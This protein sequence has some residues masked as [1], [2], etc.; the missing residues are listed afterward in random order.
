MKIAE[1]ISEG[2]RLLDLARIADT[3][4]AAG[5]LLGHLL[6]VDRTYLLTRSNEPVD[7][8]VY[9]NYLGLIR[10]RAGGEPLQ[11]ITGRQEF[12]GLDFT[13]TPDVLIPRPETEFLVE[14]AIELAGDRALTI[15]DVG[16]GSGC[17]AVALA[18]Y[19]PAA[20]VIATEIS[21]PALRVARSNAERHNVAERI[22]FLE[23]DLLEPLA[24]LELESAV[25]LLVSNPPYVPE[26]DRAG[27]QTEVR[28][29][30]PEGALFGGDEGLDFYRRLLAEGGRVVKPC[31]H[32]AL[33][34]GYGQL[35][36]VLALADPLVW[37]FNDVKADLQNIAR[38]LVFKKL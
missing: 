23:G 27:L 28:D 34:I 9:Q 30:E 29:Y 25:D 7:E 33:E 17:V 5:I 11:Y 2:A 1:A 16:T 36:G 37:R 6:G 35:D 14:R 19:L 3:R 18:F 13:V 31:G 24:G 20:R 12:Y 38:T 15:V 21:P 4:R 32:L 10:R 22:I 26:R 8:P